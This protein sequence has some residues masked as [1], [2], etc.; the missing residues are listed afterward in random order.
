LFIGEILD[1]KFQAEFLKKNK[2]PENYYS[3]IEKKTFI[4]ICN[5]KKLKLEILPSMLPASNQKKYRYCVL[6]SK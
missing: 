2:K 4:K 3:F 1:K 5:S 6:I